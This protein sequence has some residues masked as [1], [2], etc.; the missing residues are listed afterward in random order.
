MYLFAKEIKRFF[1][2]QPV[3]W[4]KAN[5]IELVLILLQIWQIFGEFLFNKYF[6]ESCMLSKI[7][8]MESALEYEL[9]K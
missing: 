2:S 6:L 9:T 8:P 1:F 5:S 7:G 3:L 4:L